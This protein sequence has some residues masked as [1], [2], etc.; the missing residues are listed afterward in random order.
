MLPVVNKRK[1]IIL[2]FSLNLVNGSCD[3]NHKNCW[4]YRIVQFQEYL[5]LNI[6]MLFIYLGLCS[7]AILKLLIHKMTSLFND[8]SN[9]CHI[10]CSS[11]QIIIDA[12]LTSLS[13]FQTDYLK[14]HRF[15]QRLCQVT[16]CYAV[17]LLCCIWCCQVDK[18]M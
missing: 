4:G 14:L 2:K 5:E 13:V 8:I 7:N 9:Q 18:K 3:Y 15:S 6:V 12:L 16:L 11:D 10:N 17:F 1:V